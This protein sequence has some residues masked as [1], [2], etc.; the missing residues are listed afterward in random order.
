[1]QKP[2]DGWRQSP[3]SCDGPCPTEGGRSGAWY[4]R[5]HHAR[6]KSVAL[7]RAQKLGHPLRPGDCAEERHGAHRAPLWFSCRKGI[8][9]RN[10]STR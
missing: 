2:C 5:W 6:S 10:A 7:S 3:R 9:Q 1:M 8:P 4:I